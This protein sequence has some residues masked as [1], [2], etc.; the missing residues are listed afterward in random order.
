VIE[1]AHRDGAPFA[2]F[3]LFDRVLHPARGRDGGAD[4]APGVV[5]LAS[6]GALRAK[7]KQI[8]PAGDSLVLELPGGAGLG[9]A[10]G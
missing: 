7:G 3:A 1:I 10:E 9:K 2:V 5:R 4:G 6:G 8:V